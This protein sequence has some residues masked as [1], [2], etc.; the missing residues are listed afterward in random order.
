M[1]EE[2][3]LHKTSASED[4]DGSAQDGYSLHRTT[5]SSDNDN[6]STVGIRS[7]NEEWRDREARDCAGA[8][9]GGAA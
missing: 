4:L 6:A 1:E 3:R 9:L 5:G 7:V 8:G 2:Y